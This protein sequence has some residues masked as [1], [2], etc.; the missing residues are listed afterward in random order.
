MGRAGNLKTHGKFGF[1]QSETTFRQRKA[2]AKRMLV[3]LFVGFLAWRTP[4][5]GADADPASGQD[6]SQLSL[7]QLGNIEVT[8]VSKEPEEVWNTPAAIYVLT[9]QD[10]RRSG[11]TSIPAL[12]RLVPG[13]E[14]AR[15]DS[16]HWAI[17]MRGFGSGFS[18]S[19]LVLI[20]GRSVYTPL[21]AGVYWD[22]QNVLM[23]DIDRVEVIRGPGGTIWGANAVNGVINIITKSAAETHGGLAAVGGGSESEGRGDFRYGSGNNN[24]FNYRVYGMAFRDGEQFH[25][26]HNEFDAWELGQAGFRTDWNKGSHDKLTVQGDLYNGSEG[27]LVAVSYYSPPSTIDL[28]GPQLVSGG[29]V[30]GRWQHEINSRSDFQI[31]T[32]YDRTERL[33]PQLDETRNTFDVDFLYHTAW[34]ERQNWLVGAGGRWS[35]DSITEGA[36]TIVFA[37]AHETDQIF[38]WFLQDEISLVP[39]KVSLTLGSKFEHNNYSGFEVQPTARLLWT[40]TGRQTFWAAITRAV[41]TPSRLD[42]NLQLTDSLA[43]GVPLFLR[44]QGNDEFGS[45][46]LVGSEA[47]YRTLVAGTLFVDVAMFH[48]HYDRLYGYGDNTMFLEGTP[49][50]TR[51][52][53]QVSPV[54]VLGGD[55][56]GFEIS[57]DWKPKR[58]WQL[59]GSYSYLHLAV[60]NQPGL[61]DPLS[62]VAS[63]NGS[64][65]HHEIVAESLFDLPKGF[66][67]D[68]TYRYVSALPAQLVPSYGTADLRLGWHLNRQI[69]LSVEGQNLLQPRHPEFGGDPGPLVGIERSVYAKFI[70]TQQP[71]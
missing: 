71:R 56:N 68:P 15:I 60:H 52:I 24:D 29:N 70:W 57:P 46:E 32:Y 17:G 53:L 19:V 55:T 66:E 37:P 62:V 63:D 48:N 34:G 28:P 41:R 38:S 44:V 42:E 69:E 30:L 10:I 35:P 4:A 54:N 33:T 3:L 25:S 26:N 23:E 5:R 50:S 31:Q 61:T 51:V 64:S 40:P 18:K 1:C 59:K 49:P 7:Q 58:W 9:Q 20:D 14:V 12:L 43:A 36:A 22:V 6:L 21:Y 27:Q 67:L 13:V 2:S 11:A 39:H 16:D 45:E 47:G 65:P 8:T